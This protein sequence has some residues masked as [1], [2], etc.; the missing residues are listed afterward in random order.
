MKIQAR[1]ATILLV[2]KFTEKLIIKDTLFQMTEDILD[3]FTS[4]YLW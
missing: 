2:Q 3:I 1:I 4:V